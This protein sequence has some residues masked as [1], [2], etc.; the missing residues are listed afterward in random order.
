MLYFRSPKILFVS[1]KSRFNVGVAQ[2]IKQ[3]ESSY[4]TNKRKRK[5][6]DGDDFDEVVVES[7]DSERL[8]LASPKCLFFAPP[9]AKRATIPA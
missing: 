3:L 8:S 7:D 1:Q 6:D 9:R 2:N 5:S 4:E